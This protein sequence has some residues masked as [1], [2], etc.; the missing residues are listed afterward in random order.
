MKIIKKKCYR[1][2]GTKE[3]VTGEGT[4]CI[5]R[6]INTKTKNEIYNGY[7]LKDN[8]NLITDFD[9]KFKILKL[10]KEEL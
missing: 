6:R 5:D 7:P 1:D 9:L 3:L 10:I 4:F 8:S 2:G